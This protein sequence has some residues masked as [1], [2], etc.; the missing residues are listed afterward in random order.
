MSDQSNWQVAVIMLFKALIYALVTAVALHELATTW[1]LVASAVG[2]LLGTYLAWLASAKGLPVWAG[3]LLSIG[4]IWLAIWLGFGTLSWD[5]PPADPE[6][7]LRISDAVLLGLLALGVIFGLRFMAEWKPFMSFFEVGYVIGAAAYTF[8][9]HREEQLHRPRFLSDWAWSNG[10]DPQVILNGV[11]VGVC[12]LGVAMFVRSQRSIKLLLSLAALGLLGGFVF[13]QTA[14]MRIE[15]PADT[16]LGLTKG[17]KRRS[18]PRPQPNVVAVAILRDEY[19]PMGGH[20]YFRQ[21]VLSDFDGHRLN[22]D[23]GGRFDSDVLSDFPTG[24]ALTGE[25]VQADVMHQTVPATMVL[26]VDHPQPPALGSVVTLERR[27]NPNPRRFVVAYDATSM[28]LTTPIPRLIG[29]RSIP[30][31]WSEARRKYY[32]KGPDDPR[33]RALVDAILRRSDPRFSGDHVVEALTIK[34]YL[35]REGFYTRK[36]THSDT[37]DPTASFLFGSLRGYCVHF[38]HSAVLLLRAQGIAARVALG[39][40]VS[41][42]QRG[43]DSSILVTDQNAHA[44]PEIHLDGVGW[45][46]FDVY[47]ERSDEPPPQPVDPELWT[48]YTELARGDKSGGRAVNPD[49]KPFEIPWTALAGWTLLAFGALVLCAYVIK[50]GRLVPVHHRRAFTRALDRLSDVGMPRQRGETR[51]AYARRMSDLA[52]SLVPLTRAH[53]RLALGAPGRG[54]EH[55]VKRL[56]LAVVKEANGGLP[57]GRRVLGWLNPIGWLFTR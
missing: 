48:A 54:S 31:S 40:A 45:V 13:Q 23:S 21:Q 33:Y 22:P 41:A 26:V 46:T 43:S 9:G 57:V 52:P 27:E 29:R 17:E 36:E 19:S 20:F 6:Q 3:A 15:Y 39:Y 30:D 25:S 37:S 24:G 8:W 4:V 10:L 53:L 34:K 42:K 32:L 51:A 49:G 12:V 44:W 55:E 5:L 28:L 50:L 1:G 16:G 35:E 47:P 18:G 38:A 7:T 14:D 56:S 11:G 2:V